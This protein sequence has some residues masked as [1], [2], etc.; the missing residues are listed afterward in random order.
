ME[1]KAT[2]SATVTRGKESWNLIYW[3]TAFVVAFVSAIA[4][5]APAPWRYLAVPVAA[6]GTTYLM[7]TNGW[8]QNRVIGWMSKNESTP[9]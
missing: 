7:L 4:S 5:L 2:S 3:A 6:G 9:R 8:I 1:M